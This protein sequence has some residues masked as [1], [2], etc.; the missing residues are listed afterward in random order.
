[1][2]NDV[3]HDTECLGFFCQHLARGETQLLRFVDADDTTQKIEAAQVGNETDASE[4]LDE[5]CLF[6][7]D[8][9]ITSERDIEPGTNRGAVDSRDDRLFKAV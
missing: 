3:I 4:R 2:R 9:E 5:A 7:R 8:D 6:A 1:M